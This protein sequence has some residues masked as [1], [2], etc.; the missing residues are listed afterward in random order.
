MAK[1]RPKNVVLVTRAN[2]HARIIW[3]L[4]AHRRDYQRRIDP[5]ALHRARFVDPISRGAPADDVMARPDRTVT[6]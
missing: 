3:A 2:K 5:Y 4:L 1:R 6:G